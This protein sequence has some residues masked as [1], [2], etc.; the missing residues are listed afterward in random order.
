M[1]LHAKQ[2]SQKPSDSASPPPKTTQQQT[3]QSTP[4]DTSFIESF[5]KGDMCLRGV[6]FE[7]LSAL[8]FHP[9]RGQGGSSPPPKHE[10][11]PSEREAV[12]K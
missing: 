9:V 3:K 8:R 1:F 12:L 6:S 5:L 10:C 2:S 11:F 4:I 7:L